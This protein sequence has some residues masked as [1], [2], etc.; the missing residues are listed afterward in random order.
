MLGPD[1][2][3]VDFSAGVAWQWAPFRKREAAFPWRRRLPVLRTKNYQREAASHFSSSKLAG[4]RSPRSFVQEALLLRLHWDFAQVYSG[5]PRSSCGGPPSTFRPVALKAA[6]KQLW[7]KMLVLAI[8][9]RQLERPSATSPTHS[10]AHLIA[11]TL[12]HTIGQQT[13]FCFC[14]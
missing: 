7:G 10:H 5:Q 6:P 13:Y 2:P 4:V 8:V 1:S 14:V 9:V 12:L 3:G 11:S